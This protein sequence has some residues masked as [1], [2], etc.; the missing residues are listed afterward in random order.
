MW[1]NNSFHM[2][3]FLKETIS[4]LSFFLI[5]EIKIELMVYLLHSTSFAFSLFFRYGPT[6]TLL[7]LASNHN[8]ATSTSQVVGATCMHHQA[9]LVFEIGSH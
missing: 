5:L 1:R 7:E 3:S 6:L 9:W 2:F 4:F 8:P